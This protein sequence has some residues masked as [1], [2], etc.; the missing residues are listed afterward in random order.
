MSAAYDTEAQVFVSKIRPL[1][2]TPEHCVGLDPIYSY[3]ADGTP[4][5][6]G[7]F[8]GMKGKGRTMLGYFVLPFLAIVGGLTVIVAVKR[9]VWWMG[10]KALRREPDRR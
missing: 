6:T 7:V 4:I 3:L 9:S 2:S 5:D 8:T 1:P 10:R